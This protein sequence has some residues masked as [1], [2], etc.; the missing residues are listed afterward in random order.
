MTDA[1][2]SCTSASAAT[3]ISEPCGA[4]ALE[5]AAG[6]LLPTPTTSLTDI[7]QLIARLQ[8]EAG[9][10]RRKSAREARDSM[11]T[12]L[13]NAQKR[14]LAAMRKA[15]EERYSAA[16]WDAFGKIGSG[17]LTL[18][19]MGVTELARKNDWSNVLVQN[20]DVV[21]REGLNP[22]LDGALGS[23]SSGMRRD[24]D[25]A[26]EAATAARYEAKSLE[27]LLEEAIDDEKTAKESVRKALDFLREYES[28][29]SQSQSA[30][31][32]RM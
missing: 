16:K 23:I 18:G 32:H 20:A 30:A 29:L 22:L 6:S 12:A 21:A 28:T 5:P 1:I 10:Q 26:D 14:E 27:R 13:A 9:F 2:R 3:G 7:G 24:A 17:V 25:A 11:Q 4:T 15:A 31:L 8:I 19:G